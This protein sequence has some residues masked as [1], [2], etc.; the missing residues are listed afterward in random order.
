MRIDRKNIDKLYI[1]IS[2]LF[3]YIIYIYIYIRNIIRMLYRKIK[4]GR[5]KMINDNI[6]SITQPLF[7]QFNVIDFDAWFRMYIN[8]YIY[9]YIYTNIYV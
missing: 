4:N 2:I 3:I 1:Y 8:M 6:L 5:I 7:R 9:I